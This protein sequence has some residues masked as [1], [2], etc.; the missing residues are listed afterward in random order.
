[1]RQTR[2]RLVVTTLVLVWLL[3]WLVRLSHAVQVVGQ[4]FEGKI[5]ACAASFANPY[6]LLALPQLIVG[7][8][9]MRSG[10][11]ALNTVGLLV[12]AVGFCFVYA[13][14]CVLSAHYR[15][16]LLNA[17]PTA[18]ITHGPY[19]FVRHPLYFGTFLMGLGTEFVLGSSYIWLVIG[20]LPL[21]AVLAHREEKKLLHVFGAEKLEAFKSRTPHRLI[22]FFY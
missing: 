2:E 17:A 3:Y 9:V 16:A 7:I 12:V 13:A 11:T 1:V 18:L 20:S 10:S 14:H 21:L 6:L 22:P 4:G 5:K 15:P 8:E 19:R